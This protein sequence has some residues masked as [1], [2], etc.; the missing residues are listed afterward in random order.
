MPELKVIHEDESILVVEKPGGLLAVP[1]KGPH[2]QDCVVNRVKAMFPD[3]VDHP[4]V[5]R[6]D[7]FTSGIM[8]LARTRQA[9]VHLGRQF[10]NRQV[11][12]EYE[13]ILEGIVEEDE[14][15]IELRFRLDPDNRPRQVYDPVQGKLGV[16]R[17]KVLSRV[18]GRTRIRFF[19]LTGR[20][21]QL[22]LHAAH[23]EGLGLPIVG[24]FLYG[25]GADGDPMFLHACKIIFTHPG[26]EQRIQFK[27]PPPF[28]TDDTNS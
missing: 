21:H 8:V 27:S 18:G 24:D 11:E 3:T 9:L 10:E 16:T 28:P 2:K 14:G 7:L 20:T 5:H 15:L 1:G 13:A 17:W 22:R 19:P 6:L 26:T 25:R 4:E 12:K 23:P